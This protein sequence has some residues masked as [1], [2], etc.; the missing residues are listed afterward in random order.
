VLFLYTDSGPDHRITYLS[1]K[2][3][4][5]AL[6]RYLDLDYLCACRTALYHSFQNPA[7]NYVSAK[8]RISIGWS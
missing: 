3:T 1:V 5:I 4:L 7:E 2:L 8:F 6:F